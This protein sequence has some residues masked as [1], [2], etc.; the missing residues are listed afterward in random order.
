MRSL[1]VAAAMAILSAFPSAGDAKKRCQFDPFKPGFESER[2]EAAEVRAIRKWMRSHLARTRTYARGQGSKAVRAIRSGWNPSENLDCPPRF[3]SSGEATCAVY[4][5]GWNSDY[6]W[7]K[8]RRGA[9]LLS[10]TH[11]D[12]GE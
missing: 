8:T 10:Y 7:K 4:R 3:S 6:R 1:Q 9:F 11:K 2:R 5:S 12:T